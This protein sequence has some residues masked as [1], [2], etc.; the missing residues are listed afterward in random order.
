M[1]WRD[2]RSA[3]AAHHA[4][5]RQSLLPLGDFDIRAFLANISKSG[6]GLARP[7]LVAAGALD[8]V[9]S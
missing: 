4:K 2:A 1:L 3:P 9:G 8:K 5:D 7:Q 6:H